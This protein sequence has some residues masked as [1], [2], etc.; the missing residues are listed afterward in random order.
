MEH[1]HE[2]R[3]MWQQFWAMRVISSLDVFEQQDIERLF[4][5]LIAAYTQPDRHYHNLEHIHHLLTIIDR[6]DRED[7]QQLDRLKDPSLVIL[8]AWFHDFVYDPQAADNEARSA[9]AAKELLSNLGMSFDLDLDRIARLILA[10]QG[11]QIDPDDADLCIFLDADLVI[12]GADPVRYKAYM[13]SIRREYDW[14]EDANYRT[15]RSRVLKSFLARDRLYY[16]DILFD[17]LEATARVNIQQEIALLADN[18][19]N[20]I[21]LDRV[22]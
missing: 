2:L 18:S 15:G 13:R 17:E 21:I 8:A 3:M 7:N 10:T 1:C 4:N 14:V 20:L 22:K 16:T 6:F 9:K 11:H 5:L 19:S 12:L